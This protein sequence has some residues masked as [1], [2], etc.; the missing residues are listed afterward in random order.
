MRRPLVLLAPLAASVALVACGT[1]DIEIAKDSPEYAGALT[2]Q[3]RC[4][5]C[6]TLEVAGTQGSSTDVD[7][8]EYKDGPN[9]NQR[10]ETYDSVLYALRNGGYSSGPMPQNIVVGKEAE[11]VARFVEKYSGKERS[12]EAK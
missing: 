1:E 5:G 2:F 12:A 11:E 9:F 4:A 8:R 10:K 3:Q 7:K 6:H